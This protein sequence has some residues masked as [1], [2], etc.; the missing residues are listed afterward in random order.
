MSMVETNEQC[1]HMEQERLT[2][3]LGCT[4]RHSSWIPVLDVWQLVCNQ[5]AQEMEDELDETQ[6]LNTAMRQSMP[7]EDFENRKGKVCTE[8]R[9]RDEGTHTSV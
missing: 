5:N 9:K 4:R 7:L 1:T 8:K 6:K 3:N 2:T